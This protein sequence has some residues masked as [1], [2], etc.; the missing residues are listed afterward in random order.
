MCLQYIVKVK[1]LESD[2]CPIELVPVVK[3]FQ[4]VFPNDLHRIPPEQEIDF[5]IDLLTDTNPILIPP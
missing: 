2:I 4:K 3:D 1:D 5:G